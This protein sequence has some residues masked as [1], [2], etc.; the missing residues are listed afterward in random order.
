MIIYI[1]NFVHYLCERTDIIPSRS[2]FYTLCTN[3]AKCSKKE[4]KKKPV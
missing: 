3:K 1:M 2:N 4:Y